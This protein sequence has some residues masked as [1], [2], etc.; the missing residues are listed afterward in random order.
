MSP[1]Y[2]WDLASTGSQA[3][4]SSWPHVKGLTPDGIAEVVPIWS[5]WAAVAPYTPRGAASSSVLVAFLRGAFSVAA[6]DPQAKVA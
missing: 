4:T 5:S 3:S 2:G 6:V 1:G